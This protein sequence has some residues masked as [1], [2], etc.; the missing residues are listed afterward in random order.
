MK[1]YL[2]YGTKKDWYYAQCAPEPFIEMYTCYPKNY[3]LR[4]IAA[5]CYNL[6]KELFEV[7]GRPIPT[8]PETLT[9]FLT[10][11]AYDGDYANEFEILSCDGDSILYDDTAFLSESHPDAATTLIMSLSEQII[12][13]D[14]DGT[15]CPASH[16]EN[17]IKI[18]LADDILPLICEMA[19]RG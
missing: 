16:R 7:T 14:Y 12:E 13:T 5:K 17:K 19:S 4:S 3:V 2:L 9:A 11:E 10:G 15:L 1:Q 8:D 18:S 6:C